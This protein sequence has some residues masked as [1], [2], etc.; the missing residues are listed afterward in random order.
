[1][2]DLIYVINQSLEGFIVDANGN[3]NWSEPSE[4]VLRFF[5]DLQQSVGT[6]LLGRRMYEAMRVWDTFVIDDLPEAQQGFAE[7]WLATDKV[8]YSSTLEAVAEPRTRLEREFEFDTVRAMKEHA[9]RDL[10]IGGAGLAARAIGTGLVDRYVLRF[11]LTIVGGGTR[12]L[13]DT[14]LIQDVPF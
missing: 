9:D 11:I 5:S 8:V 3:F 7:G 1:M 4:D 2:A 10:T 12:A 6:S 13:P 14:A